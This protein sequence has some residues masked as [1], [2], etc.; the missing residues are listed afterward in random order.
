GSDRDAMGC[1]LWQLLA[2]RPPFPGGNPL[3]KLAAHQTKRI[4]DVRK[5]A[6]DTPAPLAEGLRR[7]TS[8][9]PADRPASFAE[10]LSHWGPPRR[11][12][13]QRLIAFRRR[14]D[15]AARGTASRSRM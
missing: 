4:D 8:R 12:S 13:R 1:L 7:M 2:G 11:S 3:G 14:F 6:P 10:V 5:W 9:E 15:T